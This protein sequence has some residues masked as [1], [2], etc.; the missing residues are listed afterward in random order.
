MSDAP[1]KRFERESA[2]A[3]LRR[4]AQKR[5]PA[6]RCELCS[7]ELFEEHSHL[8]EAARRQILCACQ[9]CSILF[10]GQSGAKYQIIPRRARM[11]EDF[12]ISD[13]HWASLLIPINLAFFYRE[14]SSGRMVAMYPSPAGATE[15]LLGIECWQEIAEGNPAVLGMR[16]DVE[17]LLVNRIGLTRDYF[18]APIDQCYRLVGIIRTQ[19]RGLSGGADVWQG[20]KGFFTDLQKSSIIRREGARA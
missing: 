11:L 12:E 19:W 9:P 18:L 4:F 5:T 7:A 6:E 13:E 1:E 16:P 8:L 2:F 17:A 14:A 10:S 3:A 15:S 20:I